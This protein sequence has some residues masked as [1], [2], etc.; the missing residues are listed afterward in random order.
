DHRALE[1]AGELRG[2]LEV[3]RESLENGVENTADLTRLDERGVEVGED[4]RMLLAGVGERVAGLDVVLDLADDLAERGRLAL[5]AEDLQALQDGK[6][7]VDHGRELAG[8]DH[9]V[10]VLH[11][12]AE[13][14]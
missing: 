4:P 3:R 7:G 12:R 11:R 5:R 2:L 9:D 6:A 10:V 13:R 14:R 1:L 8:E